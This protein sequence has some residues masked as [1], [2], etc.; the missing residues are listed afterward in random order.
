MNEP[1]TTFPREALLAIG[2]AGRYGPG[3][4]RHHHGFLQHAFATSPWLGSIAVVL[5]VLVGL[6]LALMKQVGRVL[7]GIP[8]YVRVALLVT[9][10]FGIFRL[11][12]R[13]EHA[14]PQGTWHQADGSQPAPPQ[15]WAV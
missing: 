12:S 13:R 11:L 3:R 6:V 9:A 15:D 8:R 1:L 2:M 10:G 4:H 7:V 5:I 14:A